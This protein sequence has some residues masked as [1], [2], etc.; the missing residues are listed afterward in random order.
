MLS[1]NN[2]NQVILLQDGMELARALPSFKRPLLS[3]DVMVGM[4]DPSNDIL[5][6]PAD[7]TP[8]MRASQ[9]YTARC[10][11]E[12]ATIAYVM[13]RA[14]FL[15]DCGCAKCFFYQ[16]SKPNELI[17]KHN[18]LRQCVRKESTRTVL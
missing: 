7:I 18:V 12:A 13:K 9:F 16:S 4:Y 5:S 14:E 1:R 15:S 11:A 3:V 17:F 10:K 6:N 2:D 8:P